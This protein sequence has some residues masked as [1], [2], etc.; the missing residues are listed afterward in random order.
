MLRLLHHLVLLASLCVSFVVV[1]SAAAEPSTN[2][3]ITTVPHSTTAKTTTTTSSPSSSGGDSDAEKSYII[4]G[5]ILGGAPLLICV[6][7]LC[8]KYQ[9]YRAKVA[10]EALGGIPPSYQGSLIANSDTWDRVT[11]NLSDNGSSNRRGGNRT[12]DKSNHSGRSGVR[13][14]GI[15]PRS[16][17]PRNS[18]QSSGLA[19]GGGSVGNPTNSSELSTQSRE[20]AKRGYGTM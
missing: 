7:V 14:R 17:S 19:P 15:S 12:D 9:A 13:Q 4:V 1:A 3:T 6:I 16:V 11:S 2:T 18:T 5:C 10:M 20:A 8:F